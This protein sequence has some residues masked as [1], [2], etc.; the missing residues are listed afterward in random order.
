MFFSLTYNQREATQ[1]AVFSYFNVG[2]RWS[3]N[4]LSYIVDDPALPGASVSRAVAGG[5]GKTYAGYNSATGAFQAERKHGAVLVRT[6]GA[7]ITYER[8]LPDGGVEV[9]AQGDG[10][11]TYPRRIFL[12]RRIDP[13][14]NA[15]E[16]TYDGQ[17]RLTTLT[18]ATG[19]I[20]TLDYGRPDWPLVVTRVTDPLGRSAE[21]TY[22]AA[23]RLTAIT[24]VLGLTSSFVYNSAAQITGLTTPYGTTQ[25]RFGGSGNSRY[26]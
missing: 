11:A 23:G 12:T 17:L 19:R 24:D 22:D 4:W 2:P 21:L 10:A 13:A 20:T 26:L 18:D 6:Q 3:L 1:P 9:Y 25:F 15:V 14:G 7:P 5:G 8:R 16:L